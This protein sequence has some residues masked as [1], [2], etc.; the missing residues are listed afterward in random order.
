MIFFENEK[1]IEATSTCLNY[2]YGVKTQLNVD[3]LQNDFSENIVDIFNQAI[4]NCETYSP[5]QIISPNH[6]LFSEFSVINYQPIL[7]A[8]FVH[9]VLSSIETAKFLAFSLY[10]TATPKMTSYPQTVNEGYYIFKCSLEKQLNQ[11]YFSKLHYSS[12]IMYDYISSDWQS[13]R[14][15]LKNMSTKTF[16]SKIIDTHGI[17]LSSENNSNDNILIK[18]FNADFTSHVLLN[19]KILSTIKLIDKH[20]DKLSAE[21]NKKNT[22]NIT[23]QNTT[24]N[25]I[26][27]SNDGQHPQSYFT[28][29]MEAGFQNHMNDLSSREPHKIL[30]NILP[31]KI[32]LLDFVDSLIFAEQLENIFHANLYTYLFNEQQ[33]DYFYK[34]LCNFAGKDGEFNCLSYEDAYSRFIETAFNATSMSTNHMTPV[35][36][37]YAIRSLSGY[38]NYYD[39]P[40]YPTHLLKSESI[41]RFVPH[42]PVKQLYAFNNWITQMDKYIQLL[43]DLYLPILERTF[44]ILLLEY[45]ITKNTAENP[46]INMMDELYGYINKN[47][48][49]F[50]RDSVFYQKLYDE[51]KDQSYRTL[52]FNC[53]KRQAKK[54]KTFNDTPDYISHPQLT[55]SFIKQVYQQR[56]LS[57][58]DGTR[59]KKV[60]NIMYAS[61]PLP[62]KKS[63]LDLI[64]MQYAGQIINYFSVPYDAPTI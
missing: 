35:F 59:W 6:K 27:H 60:S 56:P 15:T 48:E 64:H 49:L 9:C 36:I 51:F 7:E 30:E 8:L 43:S 13:N 40:K 2:R 11:G 33:R 25:E 53:P 19:P 50:V 28:S 3:T 45:I 57:L 46:F 16:M 63:Q 52:S 14:R 17:V 20:I 29:R 18:S 42:T 47:K 1:D 61:Y 44:F 5:F 58:S 32:D 26:I 41:A 37:D 22:G 62:E 38:Y 12:S 34:Y 21:D 10:P 4:L 23:H 31:N 55:K 24:D 39:M 54:G